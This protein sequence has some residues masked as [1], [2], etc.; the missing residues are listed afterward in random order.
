MAFQNLSK[1]NIFRLRRHFSTSFCSNVRLNF[2]EFTSKNV[3]T[4]LSP[5]VIAHGMLGSLANWTSISKNL[6]KQTGRRVIAFDARN[7]G[8]SEHTD[9]MS[10]DEMSSDLVHLLHDQLNM[11]SAVLVGHSMG[12]RTVMYTALSKPEVVERQVI[13]DISPVNKKFD[14]TDPTEWSMSHFFH[15]LKSVHFQEKV[16]M[17]QARRDADA[18]LAKRIQ[19]PGIR[20]WLLMNLHEDRKT[21]RI[22]WRNNLNAIHK[23]FE[24]EIV[25]FPIEKFESMTYDGPT[26]FIG[27]SNSEYIPVIDHLDIT[28][29]FPQAQFAYVPGAGHWVHSQK[30]Y[31]FLELV[32]KFLKT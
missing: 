32:I 17:S 22:G 23:S 29:L 5:I 24:S 27:G 16:T 21:G 3:R 4:D 14:V 1:L 11:K 6:H 7:H 9:T 18:Q 10:Y 20:A 12:G 13:V 2:E 15:V 19:D 28:E 8:Y 26:L 30:P 25:N 31:E